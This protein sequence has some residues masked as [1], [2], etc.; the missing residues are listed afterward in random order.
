VAASGSTRYIAGRAGQAAL[1]LFGVI[2]I[3]FVILRLSGDPARLLVPEQ[4]TAEDIARI[5]TSL[6]LDAPI[7]VQYLNYLG[8]LV[9][10]DFGFSYVQG[11]SALELIFERLPYTVNLAL[12][13]LLLSMAVGI[14][15][16]MASAYYRRKFLGRALMPFVLIG[17]SMPAFWLGLLL[18]LVFSVKFRLLPSTGFEGA[19]SLIMPAVTLASLSMA[20]LARI[21]RSSFLEQLNADYVRTTRSRG[22]GTARVLLGHVLR[23]AAIPIVTLLGL[24]VAAL[25]GG[26]VITETIF[27]WPGLGQLTVQAIQARDFPVVQAI[28]IFAAVIYIGVNLMTDLLYAVIDPR[29]RLTDSGEAS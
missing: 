20:T 25:L 17:Q 23:N 9:R 1:Q 7:W 5:R 26:A 22:A 8:Q 2:T 19:S 13:A 6:G 3:V 21:T 15:V 16:G 29:V 18:I 12:A 11:R 10:F 14:P 27:A 4:A 28:V 24:E